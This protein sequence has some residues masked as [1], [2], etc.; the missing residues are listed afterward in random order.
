MACDRLS[1]SSTAQSNMGYMPIFRKG[2]TRRHASAQ[3]RSLRC[4]V[5][6]SSGALLVEL[7]PRLDDV[8]HM[9]ARPRAQRFHRLPQ[10]AAETGQLVVHA[11]RN[12]CENGAGYQA[13]AFQSSERER[14]HSLRNAADHSFDRVEALRPVAEQHDYQHAPF[15]ADAGQHRTDR[16]AV[17]ARAIGKLASHLSVL[18]YRICAFLRTIAPVYTLVQVTVVYR[19][20]NGE[21]TSWQRA[22]FALEAQLSL[23]RK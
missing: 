13:V 8:L 22:Q 16:A 20:S 12:G 9:A 10:R 4:V 15:I 23:S 7:G 5:P 19:R 1:W 11:G 2:A 3:E 21:I 6:C 14:E 18:R 17:L